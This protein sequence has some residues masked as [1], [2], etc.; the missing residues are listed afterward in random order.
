MSDNPIARI[1]HLSDLHFGDQLANRE[2]WWHKLAA[3]LVQGLYVHDYQAVCALER[4]LYEITEQATASNVPLLVVHTG[5]LT[6]GGKEL[7]FQTGA[8]FLNKLGIVHEVPG[9]HDKWKFISE[10]PPAWYQAHFPHLEPIV[11]LNGTIVFFRIDSNKSWPDATGMLP[12]A[13]LREVCADLAS[14]PEAIRIVL[15]HHPLFVAPQH[16]N[17]L[18]CL[19]DRETIAKSLA[20]AGADC[21]L[22]GHVHVSQYEPQPDPPLHFIA[23]SAAQ[24]C[25]HKSF[26]VLDGYCAGFDVQHFA[27]GPDNH[28]RSV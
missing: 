26:L 12:A 4:I 8:S 13:A 25:G 7:E 10:T 23:G 22:T 27:L 2:E 11:C 14:H 15:M 19:D 17:K 21:V 18:L 16:D 20:A 24:M 28:F 1:I 3:P 5:D 6:A 9:N